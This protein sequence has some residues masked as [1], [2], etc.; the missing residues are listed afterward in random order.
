MKNNL[1]SI[2]FCCVIGLLLSAYMFKQYDESEVPTIK[3]AEILSFLQIGVYS[4]KE[5]M[6][7]NVKNVNYYIYTEENNQF[8]VYIAITKK[9]NLDKL[10]EYYKSLGYDIYVKEINVE[11]K[12]FL[13]VL[14]QYELML[15]EIEDTSTIASIESQVLS[16]YEELVINEQNK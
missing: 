5:S 11:N 8:Y 1:I 14:D 2:F 12:S 16:K 15:K 3:E 10:K 6:E 9:E 7:E 4:S 13:E